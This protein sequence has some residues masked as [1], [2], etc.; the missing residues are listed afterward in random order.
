MTETRGQDYAR[1]LAALG[2]TIDV[3]EMSESTHTAQQAADAIGC[4]VDAIVKSLLLRA[5][6]SPVLVL[7]SGPRRVDLDLLSETLGVPVAMADAKSVKEIT[8]YS[9][10]AVPPL[11]HTTP[12][13]ILVDE[14]LLQ[15][16]VVWSAAGS[17]TAVF[18]LDPMRLV[19]YT[20]GRVIRVS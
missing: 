10:G 5:G 3:R 18:P 15:L 9:I 19:E 16:P 11:G 1:H 8:G 14:S 2:I 17:A 12:V 20:G 6:D 4:P 7:A 13:P